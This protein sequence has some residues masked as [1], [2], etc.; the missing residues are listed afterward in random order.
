MPLPIFGKA[1]KN[2]ADVVRS[3]KDS[4]VTLESKTSNVPSGE[5]AGNFRFYKSVNLLNLCNL[6]CKHKWNI[7][8]D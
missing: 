5:V 4:L 1:S 8:S 7:I 6:K 3:L 2:P